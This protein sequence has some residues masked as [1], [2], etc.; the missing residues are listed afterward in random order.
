[1]KILS[2]IDVSEGDLLVR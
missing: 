1:M 2:S